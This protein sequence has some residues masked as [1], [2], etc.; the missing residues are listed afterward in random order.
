MTASITLDFLPPEEYSPNSTA[1]WQAKSRAGKRAKEAVYC[2][3]KQTRQ[4]PMTYAHVHYHVIIAQERP[5]DVDNWLA[6]AKPMTDG[7]VR[8]G[9]IKAD[10]HKHCRLSISFEVDKSRAPRTIITVSALEGPLT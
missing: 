2:Y 6:R 3:A 8:A 1:C 9:L 7:L 10:D 5:R 4:E